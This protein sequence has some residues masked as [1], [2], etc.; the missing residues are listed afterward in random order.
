MLQRIENLLPRVDAQNGES[1]E[2]ILARCYEIAR[3]RAQRMHRVE[4]PERDGCATKGEGNDE[5]KE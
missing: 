3:T 4:T 5:A 1:I 2:M